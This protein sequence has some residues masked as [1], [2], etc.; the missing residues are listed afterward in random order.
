MSRDAASIQSAIETRP[1]PVYMLLR[2]ARA[3]SGRLRSVV[4][5]VHASLN[6]KPVFPRS[7]RPSPVAVGI[8]DVCHEALWSDEQQK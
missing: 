4:V 1:I 5:V 8:W 6:R 3:W 7:L 2:V